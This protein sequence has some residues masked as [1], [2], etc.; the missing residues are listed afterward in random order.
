MNRDK[1]T[2]WYQAKK[3]LEAAKITEA[4]LRSEVL[5]ELYDF[6]GDS[7]LRE[8]T[9]NLELGNDYK[10]KAVFKISRKLENKNGETQ[11]AV[12]K[13]AAM[14]NGLIY[15]ERLVKWSPELSVSEYKKLPDNIRAVIDECLTSKAATPSLEIV[16]PKK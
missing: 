16:E 3:A 15:A 1:L 8:G 6:G 4:S 9:E 14:E 13:I 10:L 2:A 7:D 12:D 11:I 5:R